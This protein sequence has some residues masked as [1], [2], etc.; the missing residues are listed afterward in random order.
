MR[1]ATDRA[2][3]GAAGG[4]GYYPGKN[5]ENSDAKSYIL[6]TTLHISGLPRTCISEKTRAKSVPKCQLFCRGCA[7]G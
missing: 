2:E 1:P 6:V 5:F 7:P 3:V 4:W